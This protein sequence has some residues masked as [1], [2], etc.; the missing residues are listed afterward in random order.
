MCDNLRRRIEGQKSLSA[1]SFAG[2][3]LHGQTG[4]SFLPEWARLGYIGRPAG[5]FTFQEGV[6]FYLPRVVF[7][8]LYIRRSYCGDRRLGS[9]MFLW[10]ARWLFGKESGRWARVVGC[11]CCCCRRVVVV[12]YQDRRGHV[13][14]LWSTSPQDRVS[15][16]DDDIAR[17]GQQH[18][19]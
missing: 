6:L 18:A 12:G 9:W 17:G 4:G 7:C 2:R 1:R 8:V 14:R 16:T 11:F 19:G 13:S 15:Q 5:Q 10:L 3:E